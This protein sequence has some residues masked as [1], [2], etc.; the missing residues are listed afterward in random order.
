[1]ELGRDGKTS[2]MTT[3]LKNLDPEQ[4]CVGLCELLN[5]QK[6]CPIPLEFKNF[7]CIAYPVLVNHLY[8][9]WCYTFQLQERYILHGLVK[10]FSQGELNIYDV[11]STLD[12][13]ITISKHFRNYWHQVFFF[14]WRKWLLWSGHARHV[15]QYH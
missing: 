6:T 12:S 3:C 1:M 5:H 11:I 7:D 13:K 9:F 2:R 10:Y 4:F 15:T 14:R 8:M